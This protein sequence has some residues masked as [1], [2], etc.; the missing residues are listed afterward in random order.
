M[1]PV[2]A[3]HMKSRDRRERRMRLAKRI[4]IALG[5]LLAV[6]LAGGAHYRL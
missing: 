4:A 2:V 3:L 1:G 6:M 5:S